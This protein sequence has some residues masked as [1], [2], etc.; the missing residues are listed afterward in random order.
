MD[1]EGDG[2][3]HVTKLLEDI[4]REPGELTKSLAYSLGAGRQS[5]EYAA[6]IVR[7]SPVVYVVGM[8]ASWNAG[9]AVANVFQQQGRPAL[10]CDGSEL[11]H[12]GKVAK[13]SAVMVLSRSG[14]STEIVKLLPGLRAQKCR[15]IAITNAPDS[16]LAFGADIVLLLN[17]ALDHQVSISM[18][19]ALALTSCLLALLSMNSLQDSVYSELQ[20]ALTESE[21]RMPAWHDRLSGSGWLNARSPTYFLGRGASLASC[22]EARLLWEEAAKLPASALP[23][24]AFRHGPQEMVR[25]GIR[26]G[27]WIDRE[28]M[29]QQDLALAG[30]L[31]H[32]GAEVLIIGQDLPEHAAEIVLNLP[33][34]SARWQFV[35]EIIPIQL[36]AE[37]LSHLASQDCDAFRICSY[38]VEEEGGLIPRGKTVQ[39]PSPEAR[40]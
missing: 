25:D 22:H 33:K 26:V 11:L 4:C 38:I 12:F 5:L 2:V 20:K 14:K 23:T 7:N 21:K 36:A 37:C 15:V 35:P 34:I 8:G 28:K 13:D 1:S 32:Y 3:W 29:R 24:G 27:L 10:L 30:D 18:Y 19:S 17:A 31:R 39:E 9:C 40:K 16:P 6:E